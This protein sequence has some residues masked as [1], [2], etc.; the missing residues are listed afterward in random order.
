MENLEPKNHNEV[1]QNTLLPLSKRLKSDINRY[2]KFINHPNVRGFYTTDALNAFFDFLDIVSS[3]DSEKQELMLEMPCDYE[4]RNEFM[5]YNAIC[6]TFLD[7]Y[8]DTIHTLDEDNWFGFYQKILFKSEIDHIK[9]TQ[10]EIAQLSDP[11]RIYEQYEKCLI[12][13]EISFDEQCDTIG[14]HSGYDKRMF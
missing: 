6:G 8:G 12:E 7:I 14:V 4:L 3:K 5:I 2:Q 10:A 9:Q 11:Q 13:Y 1:D